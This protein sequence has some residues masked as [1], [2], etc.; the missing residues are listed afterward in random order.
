MEVTL[1]V[2]FRILAIYLDS[3]LTTCSFCTDAVKTR[4]IKGGTENVSRNPE[5]LS[6]PSASVPPRGDS[7]RVTLF[8]QEYAHETRNTPLLIKRQE[9]NPQGLCLRLITVLRDLSLTSFSCL[10][11]GARPVTGAYSSSHARILGR[12]T[13]R[14]VSPPFSPRSPIQRSVKTRMIK[15]G[16]E[17]VSR[18][19]ERSRQPFRVS[20][21]VLCSTLD[22]PGLHRP[23]DG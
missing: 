4:M 8:F 12:T 14:V 13:L 22:H 6:R 23:L 1:V 7:G 20:G 9:N 19:P 11:R 3:W 18:N 15:G 2:I 16:T 17:N 5:R 10:R 21:D